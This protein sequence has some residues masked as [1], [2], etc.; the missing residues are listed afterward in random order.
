MRGAMGSEY[1][2]GHRVRFLIR[3]PGGGLSGGRDVEALTAHIDVLPTLVELAGIEK[4]EG[5]PLDGRS[6]V[7]LLKGNADGWPQRTLLVHSQRIPDPEKWRKC[8]VM[9]ERWRLVNGAELFDV[10]ADPGQKDDL[11]AKHPEVVRQLRAAYEDWWKGLS[12]VFD[13]RVHIGIGSEHESPTQLHPHDWH[14]TSQNMSSWHQGHVSS[15][16]L[17]NG[18]WAVEVIRPGTYEF[19]LRRWPKHLDQPIEA[20]GARLKIGEVDLDQPVSADATKTT[21]QVKLPAGK[22]RLQTWLTTPDGKTRGAYF[23]YVRY[24]E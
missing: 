7:P 23:V 12:V 11:A 15:G 5:P 16:H 17:G 10:Q 21:F 14:V 18:F 9:T 6:L 13:K 24:V 8:A 22:T 20:T 19:E 4:P 1:D 2:G 3:W